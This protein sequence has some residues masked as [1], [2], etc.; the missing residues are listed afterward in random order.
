[1]SE[2]SNQR[3]KYSKT[4]VN[5]NLFTKCKKLNLSSCQDFQDPDL[6]P[7]CKVMCLEKDSVLFF[8]AFFDTLPS[9]NKN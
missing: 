7:K 4:I 8:P 6:R 3:V 2:K 5:N 1:M 9:L